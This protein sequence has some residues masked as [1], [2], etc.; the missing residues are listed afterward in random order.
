MR[1]S[2]FGLL[3]CCCCCVDG[4]ARPPLLASP[5]APSPT[6]AYL[7]S[8]SGAARKPDKP[9]PKVYETSVC[10]V[11]PADKWGEIQAV[12]RRCEDAGMF[13][14]P[15]HMNVLYPF[16]PRK[17]FEAAVAAVAESLRDVPPITF[18]LS[19]FELFERRDSAVLY[20]RPSGAEEQLD[21]LQR[22]CQ[23]AVPHCHEQRRKGS[24]TP[25]LTVAHYGDGEL[26]LARSTR[27]AL[28]AQWAPLEMTIREVHAIHRRGPDDPFTCIYNIGLG[29]GEAALVDRPFPLMP[30]VEE[31]WM[32]AKREEMQARRKRAGRGRRRRRGGRGRGRGSGGAS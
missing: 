2:L 27:D 17:H 22:A 10:I 6:S 16:V 15:P 19:S 29:T 3:S 21:G 8:L 1:R 31:P 25:H 13:R 12:R 23:A 9:P 32:R 14:W 26:E 18:T 7:R 30:P 28:N 20:L 11:P 5:G 4:G 24:F